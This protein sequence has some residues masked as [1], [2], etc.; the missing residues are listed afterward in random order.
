[1]KILVSDYSG[2]P[3]QVQ[4]SRELGA[5]GHEVAH[6]FF[7]GF[8]TPKG[9]LEPG[10]DDPPGFFIYPITLEQDFDKQ[11]FLKRRAQEIEVG[12]RIGKVIDAYR[13]DVVL[14][15]NAPLDTQRSI[16][17][18]SR[19]A[20]SMFVF[21]VQDLYSEAITLILHKKFGFVGR[22]IGRYYQRMEVKLLQ[23]SDLIIAISDEFRDHIGRHSTSTRIEV[24]ENW[25]PISD[26]P[27]PQEIASKSGRPFRFVYA[28]TLGYKHDPRL[29][30]LL[31]QETD[32][33]VHVYSEGAGADYLREQGALLP[34][35]RLVVSDWVP[36]EDLG[37][38][39]ASADALVAFIDADAGRYSVPS[40]VLSY[41]CVGRPLLL[42][43]P[44]DNL[45]ARI[46]LREGAGLVI[47]PGQHREFIEK[48]RWLMGAPDVCT[49]MG[50]NARAYAERAF[51]IEHIARRF[52]AAF[53]Q[54]H[55]IRDR[56]I[57]ARLGPVPFE[58]AQIYQTSVA[59]G[60]QTSTGRTHT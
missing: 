57:T 32:A 44:E 42:A 30:L 13:P 16:L 19:R 38:T 56:E 50:L 54:H 21:W 6:V 53:Q 55:P 52:E 15:A 11:S 43:V 14:S 22:Q 4:L 46:V 8:Q 18:A 45:S 59:L 17:L 24:V 49:K 5:L 27:P 48:A 29:L 34:D 3:F 58:S 47:S 26:F 51:Q 20:G 60:N 23:S 10:R 25:A 39:L 28:G 7:K 37:R 36:F 33:E 1:V 2:H 12:R 35:G 9:D 41:L 31:A 40:K